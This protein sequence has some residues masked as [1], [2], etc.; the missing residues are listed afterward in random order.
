MLP[1]AGFRIRNAIF[2]RKKRKENKIIKAETM[3]GPEHM[4]AKKTF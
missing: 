2:N 4:P 3:K 1:P